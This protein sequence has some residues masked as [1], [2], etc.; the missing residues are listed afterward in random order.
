MPIAKTFHKLSVLW[1]MRVRI[2]SG[3]EEAHY[4]LG[5]DYRMNGQPE[6]SKVELEIICAYLKAKKR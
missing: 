3:L 4:R 2:D 5:Q 6:K 1:R